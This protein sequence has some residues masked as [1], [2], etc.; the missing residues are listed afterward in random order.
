MTCYEVVLTLK[1]DGDTITT[2]TLKFTTDDEPSLGP[3]LGHRVSR[4]L[5]DLSQLQYEIAY[6]DYI[7]RLED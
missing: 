2:D 6:E 1:R 5:E 3:N 7:S 4:V